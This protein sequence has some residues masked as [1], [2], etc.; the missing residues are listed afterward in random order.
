MGTIRVSGYIVTKGGFAIRPD[1]TPA[2]PR[3]KQA[4]IRIKF[5]NTMRSK[6]ASI[7]SSYFDKLSQ[8]QPKK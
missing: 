4:K 1:S 2:I 5:V 6:S 8:L 3:T 7:I